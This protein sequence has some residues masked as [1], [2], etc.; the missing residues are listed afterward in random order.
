MFGKRPAVRP[1]ESIETL[2]GPNCQA[3]GDIAFRGGLRVEGV[4]RGNLSATGAGDGLVV[5]A[6]SG[7]VD[8][9][10]SAPTVIVSGTINGDIIAKRV[11]L[12]A[13]AKVKGDVHYASLAMEQGAVV[14]GN[15]YCDQEGAAPKAPPGG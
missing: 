12:Q 4:L 11:E 2:L 9:T 13:K 10:V 5:V 1:R 8:G 15:L 7:R 3:E 6:G 14:N